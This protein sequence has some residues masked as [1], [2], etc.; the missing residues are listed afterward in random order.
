MIKWRIASNRLK[1][2]GC[3]GPDEARR[4][5][6]HALKPLSIE[7]STSDSLTDN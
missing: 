3:D 7:M 1:Q 2:G 5:V 6:H 4:Y